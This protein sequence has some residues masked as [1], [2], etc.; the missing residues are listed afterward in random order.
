MT[1]KTEG[2]ALIEQTVSVDL[3]VHIEAA[4]A[5][6]TI[7]LDDLR[8]RIQTHIAGSLDKVMFEAS[9]D[10]AARRGPSGYRYFPPGAERTTDA[11]A[12]R[13][14]RVTL[15]DLGYKES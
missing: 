13:P 7:P 6:L 1:T 2:K 11:R 15:T 10:I 3:I 12:M 4:E 14:L 5:D 8:E 9:A